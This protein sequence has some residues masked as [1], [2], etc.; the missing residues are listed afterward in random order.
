MPKRG[1]QYIPLKV[2]QRRFLNGKAK[3]IHFYPGEIYPLSVGHLPQEPNPDG[4]YTLNVTFEYA[5]MDSFVV[6]TNEPVKEVIIPKESVGADPLRNYFKN[7]IGLKSPVPKDAY[8]PHI[9]ITRPKPY[10]RS[11]KA[12]VEGKDVDIQIE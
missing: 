2:R 4:T 7:W 5:A 9:F 3:R 8:G 12:V 6:K 11:M 10:S 1:D